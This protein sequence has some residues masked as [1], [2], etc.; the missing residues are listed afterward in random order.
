[1]A[2]RFIDT[3]LW[4]KTK[5]NSCSQKIKLLTIFITCKSDLIGVFKMAPM[6][7]NAYIGDTVTEEEIL[8]I[9]CDI[10]KLEDGVYWLER[11]CAFQYGELSETCRPHK[12]YIQMLKS[13]NLYE[14]VSKGYSKGIN[15]LQDKEQD[16]EQDKDKEKTK[17]NI[18]RFSAPLVDD[19]RNYCIE[20]KNNVDPVKWFNF[21]SAKGWMIGKNKMKDW[22]A[23]VRTWEDS[24]PKKKSIADTWS[25]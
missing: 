9:P 18:K 7:I 22:K 24:A 20:R 11:F 23:A 12:K 21:Y 14:R 13:S 2:K 25:K 17:K 4:D 10:V 15:T 6:L 19:I 3:E 16:K 5:F 8:S 1:M